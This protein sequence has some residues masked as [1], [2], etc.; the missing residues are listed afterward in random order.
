LAADDLQWIL[1]RRRSE[2]RGGWKGVSFV[3]ST[4]TILARCMREKGCP[5]QDTNAFIRGELRNPYMPKDP[6]NGFWPEGLL[7]QGLAPR[8]PKRHS[9]GRLLRDA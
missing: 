6:P 3:R 5:E 8:G 2:K 4:K 7:A 9:N 1:Y